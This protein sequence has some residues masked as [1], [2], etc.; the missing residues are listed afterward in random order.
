MR[1]LALLLAPALVAGAASAGFA[2]GQTRS[3]S[4]AASTPRDRTNTLTLATPRNARFSVSEGTWMSVDVSPDG[5]II[6]FDL[7]GDIYTMPVTGGKA[8]RIIGGNSV[9]M[10]PR[11]SPDGRTIAFIS[12]RNGSDATW[13]ADADGQRPR[14]LTNGGVYPVWTPDGREIITANRLVDVR[15]GAGLPLQGVGVGASLTGDGRYV[16]FQAGTQAAR[17][18]RTDGAITYRTALPGGVL[19]PLVSRD[20][21][22]L[23]Y[24]TRFESRTALV[25]RDLASGAERW[26][27]LDMQPET[28]VP[29]PPF[30][31]QGP[32]PPGF[33]PP[34]PPPPPGLGPLPTSAWMP[35]E[36][37]IVTSHSGKLWRIDLASGQ[38]APIPFTADVDLALGALVRGSSTMD[39]SVR[40]REIREPALSPDG[41][42]VAFTALGRAWVMELPSGKPRRLTS[43][44]N[45]VELSPVWT[46]DGSAVTFATW[47]DA[48]GGDIMQVPAA[49]GPAR[50]LTNARALYTRLTYTPDGSR[51]VF[52]RAPRQALS[53]IVNEAGIQARTAAGA[54]T[55]VNLELRWMP[56]AGGPQRPITMVTDVGGLPLGGQA[57]FTRDSSRVFYHDGTSLVSVAWDGSDRK[58]VL[59]R[60]T[61]QTVISPDGRHVLSRAGPRRH[62]YLFELPLVA[63]S[64]TIDP[65]AGQPIIPV[66]RLTR[67]GGDFASFSGDGS[68]AVWVSG[69]TLHVY[70]IAQGDKATNDSL[71]SALSR[72]AQAA[73]SQP[74]APPPVADTARRTPADSARR[75][76][77]PADTA[78]GRWAPAYDAVRH[79]IAISLAADKPA[80]VV[81]LRG[82]RIVTMKGAEIIENGDIVVTGNRI[83]A[84][85]PRGSVRIPGGART[86]DVAGKTVLPGYVDIH[87]N[88]AA[89]GQAH[90]LMVPQYLANLAF[91]ITAAR[92]PE[93]QT[94]DIF[95]YSD[96][97]SLGEM[98]GP[99][100]LPTGPVALDSAAIMRTN[101]D[102][103]TFLAAYVSP[104]RTGTVR[105]D[106]SATRPD[107]QRLLSVSRELG[108][109]AMATN[110]P[111]FRKSL[112]AILDGFSSQQGAYEIMPLHNDVAKLIAESGLVYAPMLLGRIGTQS[113]LIHVLAAESP[114]ADPKVQRFSTHRDL[115]RLTRARI[116]WTVPEEYPFE[117][118]AAGPARIVANG[119]KVAIGSGGR[120]Q[121]LA[122][123]WE[124][125]LLQKGGMPN[126]EILR[127]ATSS[128]AEAVG[129]GSQLG[130][131][132]VGKL[133]DLQVLDRNPLENIRN[134]NSVRYVMKNGRLYDANTLDQIAPTRKA[135]DLPWW[136]AT[137]EQR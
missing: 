60:A 133:A 7:L 105:S 88:L 76:T 54:G 59:A 6:V 121:G 20:G 2:Q 8:T 75:P 27:A 30:V 41:K 111:D 87:A 114:H 122:F 44:A 68:R 12:D 124:M 127:S 47:V 72:P 89:P 108:L 120:V 48:Q 31:P 11:F 55:E 65:T 13:L 113:G 49:G 90:R 98:T 71:A 131:I 118:V 63:D 26:V 51:L 66:R 117:H 64:I 37:S 70:D 35:D 21:K 103:R 128:G 109:T 62:L 82:A 77:A 126:H 45:G 130:S 100:V 102:T 1:L 43:T 81:V 94:T 33:T 93:A 73:P 23:A 5:S 91:G 80:G 74:Q 4:A 96:R 17:Y 38:S 61:P 135:L 104:W 34:P 84:V 115:D 132:E 101:P 3:D 129:L 92:D 134:T 107:R 110:A 25:V 119:G 112:S 39:D 57:H 83:T 28:F 14:L 56:A 32:L 78:T 99:R 40:V 50:N 95:S 53:A 125:W 22:R 18:D 58:V 52:A 24:F 9:D 123:H 85:G 116:S 15:G 46:P 79:E 97:L 86:I 10:H 29:P 106:L 67:A 42:Q 36:R 137:E 19:R 136:V 16:W 69:T